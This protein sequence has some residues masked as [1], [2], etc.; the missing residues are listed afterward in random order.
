[1]D[2][3]PEPEVANPPPQENDPIQPEKPQTARW[4]LEKTERI[5]ALLAR[6]VERLAQERD[7]AEARGD[8]AERQRLDIL[9]QR[10]RDRLQK[11]REEIQQLAQ[12]AEHEPP[13]P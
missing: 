4:R 2:E 9:I 10:Q 8:G 1:E 13:E 12:Q 3:V 6:D 11:L 5:N 7:A